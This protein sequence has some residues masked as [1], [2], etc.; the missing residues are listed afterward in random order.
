MLDDI[1]GHDELKENIRVA[2][3]AAQHRGE[4]LEHILLVGP[5][6]L[7]KTHIAKSIGRAIGAHLVITQGN[8]LTAASTGPFLID[9]SKEAAK[10]GKDLCVL[11]D[12]IH[13]M[14]ELAQQE[15]YWPMDQNVVL[16]KSNPI[17]LGRFTI[18]GTT[19]EPHELDDKSLI[20]R[21]LHTWQ[22][23][24][25]AYFDSLLILCDFLGKLK[26]AAD[27][28]PLQAIIG[29]SRGSPR[30]L[31]KY[32]KKI[33][34]WAH[35]RGRKEILMTDVN[36]AFSELGIDDIGLDKN[37][38]R[39][40]TILLESDKPIGIDAIASQLGEMK[41]DQ[42]R[43]TIEPYLWK[44]GFITSSNRGRELTEKGHRHLMIASGLSAEFK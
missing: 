28:D 35:S 14:V 12:E 44:L 26:V 11:I 21:F 17:P 32:A 18:I 34:D 2:I 13:E 6:G 16:T 25:L 23:E 3:R 30:L 40:L 41:T 20:N 42:V 7:G 36:S 43:K 1:I 4:P 27:K 24:E 8:R 19:T 15:L 38:R 5:G 10:L 33:R 29:R 39:Y 22:I 31:K 37:Q 9:S